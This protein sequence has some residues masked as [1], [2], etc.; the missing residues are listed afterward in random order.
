MRG[1]KGMKFFICFGTFIKFIIQNITFS[2]TIDS[3]GLA[4]FILTE[5]SK[6]LLIII[7]NLKLNHFC[8]LFFL[9]T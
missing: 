5:I 7:W 6:A 4:L 1:N 8:C 2:I 3:R 9:K